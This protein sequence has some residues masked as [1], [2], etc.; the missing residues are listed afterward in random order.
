[1]NKI[2]ENEK[3]IKAAKESYRKALINNLQLDLRL[4]ELEKQQ[5]ENRY[6]DFADR[7]PIETIH[8]LRN[9]GDTEKDDSKFVQ[10]IIHGIYKSK[11]ISFQSDAEKSKNTNNEALSPN[12]KQMIEELFS[13]RLNF[14]TELVD[15]SRKTSLKKHIESAFKNFNK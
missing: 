4:D 6:F 8:M 7:I 9:F 2:I 13:I 3:N 1:M 11:L 12:K 15:D 5:I 14:S 10:Q